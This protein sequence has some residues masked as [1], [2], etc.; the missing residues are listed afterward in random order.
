[1]IAAYLLFV[2]F[3]ILGVICIYFTVVETKVNF[4][5]RLSLL[6]S[7]GDKLGAHQRDCRA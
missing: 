2:G 6:F 4:P 3:D 5:S 7:R 1:M